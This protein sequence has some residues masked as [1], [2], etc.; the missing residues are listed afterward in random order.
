[1]RSRD[2]DLAMRAATRATELTR[3]GSY[4]S[5]EMLARAQFAS[6]KKSE[7]VETQKEAL[8]VCKD[9][10]DRPELEKFLKL[11]QQQAGL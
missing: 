4:Q 6:G 1:V 2:I 10:E 5:L 11:F 9:E 3:G 8:K 7:A